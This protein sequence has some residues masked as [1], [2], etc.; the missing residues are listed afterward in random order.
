M[1]ASKSCHMSPK[2]VANQV[3]VLK[4]HVGR[5]LEK[6]QWKLDLGIQWDKYSANCY[7]YMSSCVKDVIQKA[8]DDNYT[9]LL[10]LSFKKPS[11]PQN[12]YIDECHVNDTWTFASTDLEPVDEASDLLPHGFGLLSGDHI[13]VLGRGEPVH[14]D[15]VGRLLSLVQR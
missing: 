14:H 5:F 8:I 7:S 2:A 9:S 4:R 1:A 10:D 15:N 12:E 11:T 3:D 13:V 6:S